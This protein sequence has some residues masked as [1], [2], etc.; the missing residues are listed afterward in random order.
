MSFRASDSFRIIVRFA[1]ALSAVACAATLQ[2][3]SLRVAAANSSAPNAVYDV[4]FNPNGTTLLNSDGASFQSFHSLVY[5]Q[6][7]TT[8]NVDLVVADTAGGSIVRYAGPT[9]MPLVSSTA[10][11]SAASNVPGPQHPD[12]LSVDGAGNLYVVTTSPRP[13]IW[14]LQPSAT[15]PGGFAAPLLLDSHF[16][17]HEVDSLVETVVVPS[18]LPAAVQAALASNGIQAGDLLALVS[19][20]DFDPGDP[21]EKVTVFDYSAAS[22]AAF[23]AD[24]S[25]PIA[26]PSGALLEAQFPETRSHESPLPAGMDIWPI[27]GSL[28]ISTNRGTILEYTLPATASATGLWTGA[29]QTTFADIS[30]GCPPCPFFKLRAG[31]QAGTAY[32]F[33]AQSTGASSGNILQFAVP[34]ST[35][36]PPSGFA[37]T[38]PTSTVATSATTTSSTTTGSPEGLAL[39][40]AT[41]VV[42]STAS[43]TSSAGCN[44]TG[45]LTH[46]ILPGPSGVGPQGV[47]GNIIE[48]TCIVTD[49]RLQANG[50]CPGN[51]SIAA[52][53]PGFSANFIPPSICG[54]SGPAGNQ[55]A[56]IQSTANGVDNVPGVIVQTQENP[57]ALIPGTLPTPFC[58]P[59]QVL[60]WSPRYGS[61]EGSIPE[62]AAVVDM[63]GY[64][65]KGG[66]STRGNSMWAIGG[67]LSPAVYSTTR[68]LVGYADQKLFNLGQ[69]II[70]AP[71]AEPV[72][73]QLGL[74]LL[75]SAFL[76]DTWRYADAAYAIYACDQLV[77]NNAASFGASASDPNVYGD[78]RGRLGSVY[79]TINSR[80]LQNPPNPIWPLTSAPTIRR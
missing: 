37:F 48:Q 33:V 56:I 66:S 13:Q 6:N 5:V 57:A 59:D 70:S 47:N 45:G 78:V 49:T 65:D 77:A 46:V 10:V 42:A 7:S 24:S 68:D 23:L 2:A 39:A 40:P 52:Q 64:C 12:G 72:K 30:C 29:T 61:S 15:A 53:C 60:G 32:A 28:L 63:T 62:G 16:A 69:T 54:A 11:W 71:I 76:L 26:A 8:G 19:D 58:P 20:N 75:T 1:L 14:V 38:T 51:L 50:S 22:I 41:V 55:F 31:M 17:G 34:M 43:C 80:I 21:H 36:T 18:T 79:Y 4:L 67:Q 25:V 44:P 74:C 35:A 3:Q 73:A 9:G 27:D